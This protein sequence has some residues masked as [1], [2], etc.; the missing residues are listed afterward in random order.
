ML[1]RSPLSQTHSHPTLHW[2]YPSPGCLVFGSNQP[3]SYI[4]R[5]HITLAISEPQ[6]LVFWFWLQTAPQ[7][8]LLANTWP[9]SHCRYI[10]QPCLPLLCITLTP[11]LHSVPETEPP[12]L[13]F[14]FLAQ[15]PPPT[16]H[17]RMHHPTAT[18]TSPMPTNSLHHPTMPL[19][20]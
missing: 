20:W 19:H 14:G 1:F 13:G 4:N 18:P 9:P 8:L 15:T 2:P 16:S 6:W 11:N 12:W 7:G 5:S 10:I 17:W 3:P